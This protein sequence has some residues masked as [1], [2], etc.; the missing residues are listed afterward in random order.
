[1]VQAL[2]KGAETSARQVFGYFLAA[3]TKYGSEGGKDVF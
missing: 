3:V 1:M 2:A